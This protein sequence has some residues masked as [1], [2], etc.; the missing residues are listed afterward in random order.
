MPHKA[1]GTKR[2]AAQSKKNL[3]TFSGFVNFEISKN[4][5]KFTN[6]LQTKYPLVILNTKNVSPLADIVQ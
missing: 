2:H 3:S 6:T 1:H 5:Q 4:L